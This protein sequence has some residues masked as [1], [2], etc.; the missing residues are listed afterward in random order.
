[1]IF[2]SNSTLYNNT[3]R[4]NLVNFFLLRIEVGL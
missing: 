2:K 3:E 4:A 1:M